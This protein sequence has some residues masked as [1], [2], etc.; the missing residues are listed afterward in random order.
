MFGNGQSLNP[1]SFKYNWKGKWNPEVFYGY[2]DVVRHRG[3]TYYC[4]TENLLRN[5]LRGWNEEPGKTGS[6]WTVHTLGQVNRGGWGPHKTY[7]VGDI[8]MYKGDWFLCKTAG[9]GIHPV[10]DNGA[11]TNKWTRVISSPGLTGENRFVPLMGQENPLGWTRYNGGGGTCGQGGTSGSPGVWLVEWSGNPVWYS[12]KHYFNYNYWK[13]VAVDNTDRCN[14]G[15][16][17]SFQF[18][19]RFYND[20][21]PITGEMECVQ[22]MTGG[23]TSFLLFNNGEVYAFGYNSERQL[24]NNNASIMYAPIRVGGDMSESDAQGVLWDKN[25]TGL[26]RDAFIVK[27]CGGD[28]GG[29]SASFAHQ[30]IALDSEGYVWTWGS[31]D[32]GRTGTGVGANDNNVDVGVPVKLPRSFFGGETVVD[33]YSVNANNNGTYSTYYAITNNERVYSWGDNSTGQAGVGVGQ[34]YVRRPQIVF[35]ANRYG[36]I[37]RLQTGSGGTGGQ[38]SAF[39]LCNDGSVHFSGWGEHVHPMYLQPGSYDSWTF[40]EMRQ[41][42]YKG[43]RDLSV[44]YYNTAYADVWT[45][46]DDMWICGT[47]FHTSGPA[48]WGGFFKDSEGFIRA[49]GYQAQSTASKLVEP[50]SQSQINNRYTAG[51]D[52]V[53]PP[54]VDFGSLNGRIDWAAPLASHYSGTSRYGL[55]VATEEGQSKCSNMSY[56]TNDGFGAGVS[57]WSSTGSWHFSSRGD[58]TNYIDEYGGNPSYGV[59]T[60]RGGRLM[61]RVVHAGGACTDD[62]NIYGAVITI[63][64][65]GRAGATSETRDQI[66]DHIEQRSNLG[67]TPVAQSDNRPRGGR[68]V[69][70]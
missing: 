21:Q 60:F 25:I 64:E 67:S 30:C 13:H 37:K 33:L 19:D 42:L 9:Q 1:A 6:A 35:D 45:N 63:D 29:N 66:S 57:A 61:N 43:S 14:W 10:Y 27:L 68:M 8:V 17:F 69:L 46:V 56:S 55:Y 28:H 2:R 65:N 15:K 16:R 4:N 52:V 50:S 36:G 32:R 23:A 22:L 48:G 53:F 11:L 39:I 47:G 38:Q 54:I 5:G 58:L 49:F 70:L 26:F 20:K 24:G 59:A 3:R 31:G 62:V 44:G 7:E 18:I 41:L 12:T 40:T 51:S 34:Y